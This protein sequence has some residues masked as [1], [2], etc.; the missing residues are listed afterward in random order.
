MIG[1][2]LNE[3][4]QDSSYFFTKFFK[5]IKPDDSWTNKSVRNKL[6]R[7]AWSKSVLQTQM[8]H[9]HA[10]VAGPIP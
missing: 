7:I 1:D 3:S 9:S 10:D 6:E 2:N 4:S 5:T 8:R